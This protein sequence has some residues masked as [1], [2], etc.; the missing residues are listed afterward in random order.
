MN[1]W[2]KK[3]KTN[4]LQNLHLHY[5]QNQQHFR[6]SA[7][8]GQTQGKTMMRAGHQLPFSRT[9]GQELE[10]KTLTPA[11]GHQGLKQKKKGNVILLNLTSQGGHCPPKVHPE[12]STSSLATKKAT[13]SSRTIH[14]GSA[15]APTTYSNHNH[16]N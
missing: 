6:V 10:Q 3:N 15:K 9:L 7:A 8:L 1:L 2:E 14:D 4:N 13:R 11:A 5:H 16:K 12:F